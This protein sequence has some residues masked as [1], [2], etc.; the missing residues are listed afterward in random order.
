MPTEPNRYPIEVH[1]ST[2]DGG[3]I[4]IARDLP[5]CSA[6]GATQGKAIQEIQ[7]AIKAWQV[8]AAAAHNPIPEPSSLSEEELPSGRILLRLPRS[9]H[10]TLIKSAKFE[11]VSL[12]Q[13]ILS[14]LSAGVVVKQI[15]H[16]F[17]RA[18]QAVTWAKAGTGLGF[19]RIEMAPGLNV[20]RT[21]RH[22]QGYYD[23]LRLP[24]NQPIVQS[25][26]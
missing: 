13:N 26:G 11:N 14:L 6:F 19:T 24:A 9:L 25:E 1:Y 22:Q 21:V 15:S 12:N 10:A 7:H 17:A 2:D 18:F 23:L 8:A 20:Q 5:G 16:N 4:A 3:F